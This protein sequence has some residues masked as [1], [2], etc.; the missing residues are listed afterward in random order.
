MIK[1]VPS[2][3][4]LIL[5][6][7]WIAP[8]PMMTP[9][10]KKLM[11]GIRK[12]SEAMRKLHTRVPK[13][14]STC[15]QLLLNLKV[16]KAMVLPSLLYSCKSWTLYN[17]YISKLGTS[18]MQALWIILQDCITIIFWTM[19]T[20]PVS[21]Q[22]LI[23]WTG[24]IIFTEKHWHSQMYRDFLNGRRHQGQPMKW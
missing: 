22:C 21:N 14:H 18:H 1:M 6:N 19:Q 20:R 10:T 4:M 11:L 13:K 3:Q 15:P 12:A 8:S 23:W 2:L 16:Y 17:R 7:T 24:H 5:W 9:W